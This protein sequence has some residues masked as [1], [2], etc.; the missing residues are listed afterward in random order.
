M[1]SE[2]KKTFSP[3]FDDVNDKLLEKVE[4]TYASLSY[5]K[6]ETVCKQGNFANQ[7]IFL[8]EGLVKAY[9]EYRDKKLILNFIKSREIIGLSSLLNKPVFEY[10][11]TAVIPC[12]VFSIDIN[13][14]AYLVKESPVFAERIISAVNAHT[15]LLFERM[16][17]LTQKQLPGLLASTILYFSKEIYKSSKFNLI[18]SRTDIA[19]Y[20]GIATESAIRT[21]KELDSEKIIKI[22]GKNVEIKN[23]RLLEKL[24]EIG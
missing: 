17:T 6:G 3:W 19:D 11:T 18:L 23:M 2:I 14:I 7:V 4:G 12:K 24:S 5:K 13:V 22:N 8:Q 21:L 9:K 10:T 16:L 15:S 1:I 20:C